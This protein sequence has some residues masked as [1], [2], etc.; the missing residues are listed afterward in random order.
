MAPE[1]PTTLVAVDF[2]LENGKLMG[3]GERINSMHDPRVPASWYSGAQPPGYRPVCN[4]VV[5]VKDSDIESRG[6]RDARPPRVGGRYSW[7]EGKPRPGS[8]MF[9]IILPVGSS[10]SHPEPM[11]KEAKNFENR[12]AINWELPT[13]GS[14]VEFR[15][16]LRDLNEDVDDEIERINRVIRDAQSAG[17]EPKYDVALSYASEDRPYVDEVAAALKENG[18]KVFYDRYEDEA[19][20]LWG[21]N[22]YDYLS[23]VYHKRARYTVIFISAAYAKK[24]WAT[25]E[26]QSA[27]ARAFSEN[28]EY[29]LPARFDDTE[30]PGLLDTTAYADL[31]D[32]SPTQL[33]GRITKKVYPTRI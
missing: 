4:G 33:A 21:M 23:E 24:K 5:Y 28:R 1:N 19:V 27:Q 6:I 13:D 8:L 16:S 17:M 9:V 29:I 32:I 3:E 2:R 26:R 25:H 31:K 30:V 14:D 11:P 18:I 22:L 10:L 20:R 12:I 15:W 7:R